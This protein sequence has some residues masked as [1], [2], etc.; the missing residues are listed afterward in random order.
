MIG[1]LTP[2]VFAA[3][4]TV[5]EERVVVPADRDVRV[6][7]T[8]RT[9]KHADRDFLEKAAKAGMSEVQI[10]RIAATRTSNADVKRFA[11]MIVED[12]E[13]ANEQLAALATARGISL[14][15]KELH[16]DKWEKRDAKN[17]DKDYLEKMVSDHEDT[18]KLFEKQAR[19]GEDAESVAFARKHL[20]KLQ[21]HLQQAIDLKRLLTDK[22]R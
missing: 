12:H 14:P 15:A 6:V 19:N 16:G 22:R 4:T 20:P 5:R 2:G 1:A 21:Q 10:S 9:L 13:S 17:F 18:V 3:Q 8:T 7:E 11:Q